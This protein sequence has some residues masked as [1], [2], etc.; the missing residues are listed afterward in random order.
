MYMLPVA[1]EYLPGKYT[2][3]YFFVPSCEQSKSQNIQNSITLRQANEV[4]NDGAT[5]ENWEFTETQGEFSL[6]SQPAT[7]PCP[8]PLVS[9]RGLSQATP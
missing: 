4:V 2:V 3:S 9:G 7:G 8:C 5:L 1:S 6:P